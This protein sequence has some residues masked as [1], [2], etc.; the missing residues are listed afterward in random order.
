[1]FHF[2]FQSLLDY[3]K[4]REDRIR[5]DFADQ[6]KR[7]DLRAAALSDLRSERILRMDALRAME[8]GRSSSSDIAVLFAYILSLKERETREEKIISQLKASL[9]EKRR[10]LVHAVKERKVM[11]ALRE[12][13]FSES[14][15]SEKKRENKELDEIAVTRFCRRNP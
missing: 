3:R 14:R 8:R 5:S 6:Q 10:E 4:T 11:E 9:E 1:M 12:K 7:I 13:H 2:R 15:E